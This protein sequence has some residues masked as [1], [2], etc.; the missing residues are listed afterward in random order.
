MRVL[1][2]DDL[3]TSPH[4]RHHLPHLF[5]LLDLWFLHGL[6]QP[7]ELRIP[8]VILQVKSATNARISDDRSEDLRAVDVLPQPGAPAQHVG[9]VWVVVGG[10]T[11]GH[12]VPQQSEEVRI[13]S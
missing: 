3:K 4:A 13:D 5:P 11:G 2:E 6:H 8:K 9:G 7:A 12:R 10:E 1:V